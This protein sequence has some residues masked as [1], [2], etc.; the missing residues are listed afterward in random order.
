MDNIV[1]VTLNPVIDIH[2]Y[3]DNFTVG[4]DNIA[5]EIHTFAAG[6]GMNVSRALHV[7]G[8]SAEAFVLLGEENASEYLSLASSYNI[9][10]SCITTSG[11]VRQNV[12][13]NT[14]KSE[15]RVCMKNYSIMPA[16]LPVLAARIVQ[17]ISDEAVIVFSG[18]LPNG[19]SIDDFV[20]F[21]LLIKNTV[22]NVKIVLDCPNITV[23]HLAN[24]KPF[25]IKP[26][27]KECQNLLA[28]AGIDICDYPNDKANDILASKLCAITN[29]K[30]VIVSCGACGAIYAYESHDKKMISGHINAPKIENLLTTVGAG[31]SMLAGTL[32]TILKQ[33]HSDIKQDFVDTVKWGVA[34]GSAACMTKGTNPPIYKDIVELY[35]TLKD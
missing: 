10:V 33:N 30:H 16:V 6:K 8:I 20:N 31:D 25:L 7:A 12:S 23:S 9:P 34:F 21:I 3:L 22:P 19:I 24:I 13:I 15:T 17:K 26:N 5:H 28:E 27:L 4:K 32:A 11:A 14:P 2:Y 1:T 29:S 18:S 35:K